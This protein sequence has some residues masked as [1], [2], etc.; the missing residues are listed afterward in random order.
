MGRRRG[1]N[2]A[3]ICP[4]KNPPHI[5]TMPAQE[6]AARRTS[7]GITARYAARIFAHMMRLGLAPVSTS[8]SARRALF[9]RPNTEMP[10]YAEASARTVCAAAFRIMHNTYNGV[11][12]RTLA[13]RRLDMTQGRLKRANS[14]STAG[15]AHRSLRVGGPFS[16]Q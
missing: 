14:P 2:W 8:A 12:E 15:T 13:P 3:G 11:W 7:D 16:C 10:K 9:S 6:H 1:V 5:I 4:A